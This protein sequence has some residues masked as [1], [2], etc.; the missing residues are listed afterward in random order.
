MSYDVVII[1]AGAAGLA[2]A[3]ELARGGKTAVVLE[4]R[5][6]IGG[7]CWSLDVPG[8]PV[9]VE[10]GA[11]FIHGR[12]AATLSRMR[13][14]G[15]AAIDAP[16]L[17]M[18]M[19]DGALRPRDDALYTEIGRFLRRHAGALR[20][21]D[22]SFE[23]F[24]ARAGRGLSDAAR[25]FARM[26]VQGYD[27]AQPAR[28]SARAIAEE[29]IAEDA[30]RPGHFRPQGGYGALL[31][32]LAGSLDGSGVELRLQHAVRSVRWQPGRVEVEGTHSPPAGG[33]DGV[34]RSMPSSRRAPDAMQRGG[35]GGVAHEVRRGGGRN[36]VVAA[37]RAIVTLPLGVLKLPARSAGAVRFDPPLREK[38]AALEGLV[39]GAVIK[40]ALLFR[41]A[42][43]EE[44][45]AARYRGVSFFHSPRSPFPTFWTA[46]PEQT[47]LVVAWA[48][49]PKAARFADT[50]APVIVRAAAASFASVFGIRSGIE[51]RLAAAWVHHWQQD[52]FARGAYSYVAVGGQGA[53]RALAEPLQDTLYFAGEAADHE[54]EH[55]T[56]AGAL[57]SGE[58][59]ARAVLGRG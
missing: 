14:A 44:I 20:K 29:W 6:R 40:A 13:R 21:K 50:A 48:G 59:A 49:G 17:R 31:S 19:I 11:E 1:G 53:R 27:A 8:L 15:I 51:E 56:V 2:A 16:I 57:R 10:L 32:V 42:F 41:T 33:R 22:V 36:F 24:L 9:P 7:R 37:Q 5:D 3:V 45:E 25:T 34:S 23:A 30:G 47:P 38:R 35:M 18:A 54:G 28:A 55:G 12:P 39:S 52:P 26:R 58:R 4:A 46:L 43:W